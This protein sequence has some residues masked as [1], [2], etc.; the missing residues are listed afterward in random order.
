MQSKIRLG[1]VEIRRDSRELLVQGEARR[2]PWRAFDV[3]LVLA[4]RPGE[5][6]SKEELLRTVWG[7]QF[8]D[9]S[10]L[11][12]AVAQIRKAIGEITPGN[13]YIET[14]PRLGYRMAV[15]QQEPETAPV[16]PERPK[17]W[18]SAWLAI[19]AA[20]LPVVAGV[21]LLRPRDTPGQALIETPFT[22]FEGDELSPSF[23]PDGREVAFTWTKPGLSADIYI[24]AVGAETVQ[25]FVVTPEIEMGPVFSPNGQEIA[26]LRRQGA[27]SEIVVKPRDGQH[28]ERVVTQTS[29]PHS[30]FLGSPGPYLTWTT[31]GKGLIFTK[32]RCLYLWRFGESRAIRLTQ[33]PDKAVLGDSDPAL[34]PDGKT[35]IFVRITD[36]GSSA[37][38]QLPLNENDE[39]AG[40]PAVLW[41]NNGV[42][43]HSPT[44]HRDG[45]H[46]VFTSGI[47]GRQRLW[48]LD[49]RH[50][51]Q[52][53]KPLNDA[54]ADAQQPAFAPNSDALLYTRWFF[55]QQVWSIPLAGPGRAAADQFHP[56]L[57]STRADSLARLA[58]DA[59][60]IVFSS[61]RSGTF[62]IWTARPDGSDV[63]KVTSSPEQAS[64]SPDLS[65]DGTQVAFDRLVNGQRDI[66]VCDLDGSHL[67]QITDDP[68][69]DV[70][71]RWSAD[72]ASLY[73]SSHR[74]G[75][76]QIWKVDLKTRRTKRITRDGGALAEESPDGRTVYFT[77]RDDS[78]TPLMAPSPTGGEARPVL[79]SVMQR[80]F[81]VTQEGLYFVPAQTPSEVHFLP[82]GPRA[83]ERIVATAPTTSIRFISVDA[84]HRLL[85]ATIPGP[86]PADLIMVQGLKLP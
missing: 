15:I 24:K 12:Q 54:G 51:A 35:L 4:E 1:E 77:L 43:N 63:R 84:Q 59:S 28:P 83:K 75:P 57:T 16:V 53:A 11:T 68:A 2:L 44:W 55:R 3:L 72:G 78:Q 39:P 74:D 22:A 17:R 27:Y 60:R 41:A 10:N 38:Y 21:I 36:Y 70:L 18:W 31:D 29:N 79:D 26:F 9:S 62:E 65:P 85:L 20:L 69:D 71:P 86:P 52:S 19:G 48:S 45:H 80:A 32:D 61:D 64:G 81:A 76:I 46:I 7:G 58:R 33:P 5:V 40:E 49:V 73:F 66:F 37:V 50:P 47:W 25:P 67:Q 82:F 56:V 14:V 42:W 13:S 8:V 23:S 34:S 6:I 30:A